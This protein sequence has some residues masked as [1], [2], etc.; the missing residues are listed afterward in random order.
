[1]RACHEIK[2]NYCEGGTN[3]E[4]FSCGQ[5]V[6]KH[7]SKKIKYFNYGIKRLCDGCLDEYEEGIK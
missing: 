5:P 3:C 1:M 6:C 4:C 2:N 7:C